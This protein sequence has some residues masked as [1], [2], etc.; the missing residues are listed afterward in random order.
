MIASAVD[1]VF[2]FPLILIFFPESIPE[3]P[4]RLP[5][6]IEPLHQELEQI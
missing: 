1:F 2:N 6:I 3:T 4:F 5:L